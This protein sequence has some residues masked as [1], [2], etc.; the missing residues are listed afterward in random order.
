MRGQEMMQTLWTK[1]MV[2]MMIMMAEALLKAF[3]M[4]IPLTIF[5]KNR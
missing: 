5:D 1:I 2:I 3:K 4:I